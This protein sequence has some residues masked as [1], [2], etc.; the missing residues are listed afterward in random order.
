MKDTT[1][2]TGDDGNGAD[3]RHVPAREAPPLSKDAEDLIARRLREAYG[4]SLQ[5][6][7][8]DKF[9]KLL[10]QLAKKS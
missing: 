8:P 2:R 3:A 1:K 7:V 4:V 10:E 5:E 9:T 6:P